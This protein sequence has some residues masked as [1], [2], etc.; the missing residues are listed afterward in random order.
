MAPI[1]AINVSALTHHGR[2]RDVNQDSIAV[3]TWVRNISMSEPTHW[4]FKTNVPLLC[5]IADG[6][7]GH[8]AGEWASE[9]AVR[10]LSAEMHNSANLISCIAALQNINS[11]IYKAMVEQ[12]IRKG[13]G[14]T[15]VGL[16]LSPERIVW[17]N[18]GDSRIYRNEFGELIQV[19]IDD[20][21]VDS[22]ENI[23]TRRRSHL[24]T[25]TL[26]GGSTYQF[27]HPHLGSQDLSGPSRW[28]LCSDGLTDMV[29]HNVIQT[30]MGLDDERAIRR[31]FEA[32]MDAGG[33]DNISIIIVSVTAYNNSQS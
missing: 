30:C 22:C 7:G 9:H 1:F 32:A 29:D 24:V 10:R 27:I 5:A 19:S 8:A 16:T 23:S 20:V 11:E 25:Q 26:G 4:N 17:F 3:G 31:L 12:P 18:V 21:P 14:T 13:M 6:L 33:E 15:V 28:L 2:V